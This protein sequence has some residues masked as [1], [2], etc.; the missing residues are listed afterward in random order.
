MHIDNL[1]ERENRLFC[2]L[3]TL[4]ILNTI[5]VIL[6]AH[7][8]HPRQQHFVSSENFSS[9]PSFWIS[10]LDEGITEEQN[11]TQLFEEHFCTEKGC[12]DGVIIDLG[13][14]VMKNIKGSISID[15]KEIIEFDCTI[16]SKTEKYSCE[17]DQIRF[18]VS[19][20]KKL[21]YIFHIN[22]MIYEGA[23]I[24]ELQVYQPNGED[25]EPKCYQDRHEFVIVE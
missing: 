4:G 1:L 17:S 25:C 11:M 23:W 12:I 3:L 5:F 2:F 7:L 20:G 15:K 13:E 9:V 22:Q 14:G 21:Y 10:F 18:F 24:L 16:M 6:Y 8:I 19:E